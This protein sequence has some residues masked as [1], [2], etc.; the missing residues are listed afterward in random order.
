MIGEF[1]VV[2]G[3]PIRVE[4]LNGL[5]DRFVKLLPALDEEAVVGHILNHRMLEDV[6]WLRQESLPV[7]DLQRL[8]VLPAALR[9]G[10]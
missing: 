3:Q 5:P 9:V 6:R 4:F 7:D 10:R 8:G 2:L 1:L